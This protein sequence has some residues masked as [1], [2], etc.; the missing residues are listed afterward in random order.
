MILGNGCYRHRCQFNHFNRNRPEVIKINFLC[1]PQP[2]IP[3]HL[4]TPVGKISNEFYTKPKW[5]KREERKLVNFVLF[6]ITEGPL[7]LLLHLKALCDP[8]FFFFLILEYYV[9]NEPFLA[10]NSS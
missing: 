4:S 8:I 3:F 9:R 6:L 7:T 10:V 2:E 5:R 1:F